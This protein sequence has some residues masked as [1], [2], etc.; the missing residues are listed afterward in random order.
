MK[1]I[2]KLIGIISLAVIISFSFSCTIDPADSGGVE[3]P[4]A[5]DFSFSNMTQ[6]AW[7]VTAVSITPKFGKSSGTISNIRYA[8]STTIPQTEGT[9]AVTFDVA[10]EGAWKAAAGL[11]AGNLIVKPGIETKYRGTFTYCDFATPTANIIGE[12]TVGGDYIRT[13]IDGVIFD[14]V[15]TSGGNPSFIAGSTQSSWA[16]LYDYDNDVKIGVVFVYGSQ[17]YVFLGKD[18]YENVSTF[19]FLNDNWSQGVDVSDMPAFLSYFW[20]YK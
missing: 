12:I 3:S 4:V 9:Y 16:Y 6:V 17:S 5:E 19:R 14:F 7:S 18:S 11:S 15:R 1:N 20:G 10:A 8:G 13:D 2:R